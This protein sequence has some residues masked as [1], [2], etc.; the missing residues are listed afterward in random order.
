MVSPLERKVD[1]GT[2]PKECVPFMILTQRQR[3][4]LQCKADGLTNKE[5]AVQMGTTEEMTDHFVDGLVAIG[6]K[7]GYGRKIDYGNQTKIIITKLIQ[8]GISLNHI[9]HHLDT[10]PAEPL[11]ERER[12]I[13]ENLLSTGNRTQIAD[14]LYF[15]PK[16]VSGYMG[17]IHKKLGTRNVYHLVARATYMKTHGL[18]PMESEVEPF[19]MLSEQEQQVLQYKADGLIDSEIAAQM[20][21]T[22]KNVQHFTHYI[23]LVGL[24]RFRDRKNDYENQTR[25]TIIGLIQD[26][27]NK[28]YLKHD[29][30]GAIIEPLSKREAEIIDILC[31]TGMTGQQIAQALFISPKTFEAHLYHIHK[32]LGIRNVYHLVA[33]AT[34]MKLHGMWPVRK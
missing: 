26:G 14:S 10:P 33:R 32:K 23:G 30:K 34:Y 15:S 25:I 18:W 2:V 28:G 31:N 17:R 13:L 5:T 6:F 29:L 19:K 21:T 27:V 20:G 9:E 3:L 22:E 16:T 11:T 7:S 12:E 8:D 4:V 1:L 24:K